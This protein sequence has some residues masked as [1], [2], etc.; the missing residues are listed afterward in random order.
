VGRGENRDATRHRQPTERN[1]KDKAEKD[2]EEEYLDAGFAG[3]HGEEKTRGE[4]KRDNKSD[5]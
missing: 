2:A 4:T 3:S 1:E 5:D